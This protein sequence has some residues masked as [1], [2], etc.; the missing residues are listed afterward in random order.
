MLGIGY[1]GGQS[2]SYDKRSAGQGS[3][4]SEDPSLL[5]GQVFQKM[6]G[7][8]R[9]NS[10]HSIHQDN[11]HSSPFRSLTLYSVRKLLTHKAGYGTMVSNMEVGV[12]YFIVGSMCSIS[13]CHQEIETKKRISRRLGRNGGF[14]IPPKSSSRIDWHKLNGLC[15]LRNE[16]SLKPWDKDPRNQIVAVEITLKAPGTMNVQAVLEKKPMYERHSNTMAWRLYAVITKRRP[17]VISSQRYLWNGMETGCGGG[18]SNVIRLKR[19]H[20]IHRDLRAANVLVS[21]SLLCKIADFGLA[22]VIED[23]E[24]SPREGAKFPIKWTA[25]EAIH[26]GSFTIKSDMWSFGVLL[27][28]IIT[29]GKMPYPGMSK[30]EVMTGIQRGYRM[31]QPENC[32]SELYDIMQ[33]CWKE[34]PQD[35]PTFDYLQSVLDDFY[36]ATE[37]QYQEQA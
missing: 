30:V 1:G 31:P 6:E 11:R 20:Y 7:K 25:P 34:K 15:R 37:A 8:L 36:T 23:D 12:I 28:E 29:Y 18:K 10:Y 2:R 19:R 13:Y 4:A 17:Y 27:Y 32:P 21:E 16:H 14:Y 24:Y 33:S 9:D 5:P 3:G 26:Y 22:R 35:R